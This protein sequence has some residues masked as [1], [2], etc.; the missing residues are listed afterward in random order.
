[1]FLQFPQVSCW[2]FPFPFECI[3]YA[4]YQIIWRNV[5]GISYTVWKNGF[6]YYIDDIENK[7]VNQ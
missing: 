3:D 1:M 5:F 6:Y 4:D 2:S 7:L